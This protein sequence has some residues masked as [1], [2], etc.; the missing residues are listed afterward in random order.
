MKVDA[1]RALVVP[2]LRGGSIS[3]ADFDRSEWEIK[4]PLFVEEGLID[5][6]KHVSQKDA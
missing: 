2:I 3:A 5:P 6:S 4:Y 1:E